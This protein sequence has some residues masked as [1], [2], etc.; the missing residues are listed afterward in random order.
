VTHA[1]AKAAIC[2]T[3]NRAS[4]E[5]FIDRNDTSAWGLSLALCISRASIEKPLKSQQIL[6]ASRQWDASSVNK[7]D[8]IEALPLKK[9]RLIGVESSFLQAGKPRAPVRV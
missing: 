2:N 3:K 4:Q 5:L 7:S 1:I 9:R 6:F 8:C